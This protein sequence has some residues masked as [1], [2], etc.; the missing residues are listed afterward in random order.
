M[1]SCVCSRGFL[2]PRRPA[3]AFCR[4]RL[5][6]WVGVRVVLR[7]FRCL[8]CLPRWRPSRAGAPP[9]LGGPWLGGGCLL[10][11]RLRR[12]R[13]RPALGRP[14]R[15][16][17]PR[18]WPLCL[19]WR[20][21]ALRRP[22]GGCRLFLPGRRRAGW[23]VGRPVGLGVAPCLAPSPCAAPAP[24][25]LRPRPWSAGSS[26]G[27]PVGLRW[28]WAVPLAPIG[29][30]PWPPLPPACLSSRSAGRLAR[31]FSAAR[32]PPGSP[33]PPGLAPGWAGGLAGRPPSVWGSAWLG[34]PSPWSP[35]SPPG[36]SWS[37]SSPLLALPGWPLAR[38]GQ[39]GRGRGPGR[40]WPWRLALACLW[41]CSPSAFR[42]FPPG[43]P[44]RRGW[45]GALVGGCCALGRRRC[46]SAHAPPLG[47]WGPRG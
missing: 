44:G 1:L 3:C 25:P 20:P 33:P 26:A 42:A 35:P 12:R 36:G 7:S 17:L 23:A 8:F 24:S 40:R 29:S 47:A 38:V 5:G 19:R 2:P 6:G 43:G 28:P 11:L 39:R 21:P 32:C 18:P 46:F 31:G 16:W 15:L 4:R 30:L 45:V 14:A 10:C 37:G 22:P 34:V 13:L 9:P 41:P 27:S